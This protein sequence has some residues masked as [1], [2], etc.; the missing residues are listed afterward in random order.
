MRFRNRK[1]LVTGGAGFLGSRLTERLLAEGAEVIV[2]DNFFTGKRRNLPSSDRL[3]VVEGSVLDR[4]LLFQL[5][6]RVEFVFHF[7]VRNIIVSTKDPLADFQTNAQGTLNVLLA[8]REYKERIR[9]MIY[10][11]SSSVYGNPRYVPINED[12]PFNILSPYAASKASGEF[13]CWAFAEIYQVPITILRYSNV[14][15]V[16]QDPTNPYCGVVAKFLTAAERGEALTIYGD[17]QQTRDFTYI[18][19]AVEA[20]L[21]AALSPKAEGEVF[22]VGTGVE[23]SI[24]TLAELVNEM[25]GNTLSIVYTA[26]RDIDNIRRRVLN[27]EKIRSRLRWMPSV[28]LAEGLRLTRK[29]LRGENIGR[30]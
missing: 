4:D 6:S 18:Y 15:G 24:N 3:Q 17:G 10:A 20:T 1:A 8:V 25:Y 23:T 30:A 5:V 28:P 29:W 14:Y 11:S 21:L 12:D 9:R 2:L 13:C 22:N 27:I 26:R 7:A 19:D 16:G